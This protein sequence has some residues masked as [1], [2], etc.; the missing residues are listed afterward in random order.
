MVNHDDSESDSGEMTYIGQVNQILYVAN[1]YTNENIGGIVGKIDRL[2]TIWRICSSEHI[3]G[4]AAVT[5]SPLFQGREARE[6]EAG[7]GNMNGV[8]SWCDKEERE[9]PKKDIHEDQEKSVVVKMIVGW[10]SS[11]TTREGGRGLR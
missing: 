10:T 6:L 2:E 11:G 4:G 7:D 9:G 8:W 3:V 5:L 1:S